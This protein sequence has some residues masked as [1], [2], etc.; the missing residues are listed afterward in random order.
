M[1]PTSP[2]HCQPLLGGSGRYC[3]CMYHF[4]LTL[5]GPPTSSRSSPLP[6]CRGVKRCVRQGRG[7]GLQRHMALYLEC[8]L[9]EGKWGRGTGEGRWGPLS[10]LNK[11]EVQIK[12]TCSI[13][14]RSVPSMA[15]VGREP[16]VAGGLGNCLK[17]TPP[18]ASRGRMRA[19]RFE[20]DPGNVD[21]QVAT[22]DL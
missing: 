11:L 2:P 8:S 5:P 16:L 1:N 12:R 14:A 19:L 10:S 7:Q 22:D 15:R 3:Q 21:M 18:W 4:D 9:G 6:Q 20:G 17:D 13:C